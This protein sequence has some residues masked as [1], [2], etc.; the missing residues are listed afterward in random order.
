VSR[1]RSYV[2]SGAIDPS[3]ATANVLVYS[4]PG[5]GKSVFWCSGGKDVLMME[6]DPEGI[7]SGLAQ[8]HKPHRV[9]VTDYD[10]LQETYEWLKEDRPQD[11]K[12]VV[13]DSLTLFQDRALAD[14][15]MLD[16]I[17]ESDKQDEFVPS[18]R[19]YLQSMNRIGRYV[20]L[21][22]DLPYNFGISCHVMT[23]TAVDGDGTMMMPAVQGKGMASKIAGYMNVVGYLGKVKQP[24]D[25]KITQTMLWQPTG[26]Y[27]AKDRF[28]CLGTS[29]VHPTLPKVDAALSAWRSRQKAAPQSAGSVTPIQRRRTAKK[30]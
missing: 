27:F 11:F 13:W 19:E 1:P 5:Y 7:I 29:M 22:V 20:R 16:A 28:G 14:D 8:G 26:R 18:R 17:A 6:S 10:E 24:P 21:F 23:D 25:N 12:W 4:Y 30:G 9:K 2:A 3:L 15:I